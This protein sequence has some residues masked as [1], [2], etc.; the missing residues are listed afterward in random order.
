MAKRSCTEYT[1]KEKHLSAKQSK[2][3]EVVDVGVSYD[4]GWQKRGKSFDSSSGVGTAV[5]LK[6]KKFL[7]Y[8]TR[9][10]MCLQRGHCLQQGTCHT[11]L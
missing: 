5:G 1:E 6:M 8:M 2:E 9:N 3:E 11:R 7:N 4:M 10:T